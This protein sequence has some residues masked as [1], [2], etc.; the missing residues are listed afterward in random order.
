MLNQEKCPNCGANLSGFNCPYCRSVFQEPPHPQPQI[1]RIETR[2]EYV[3]QYVY[4]PQPVAYM[5][6]I[7]IPEPKEDNENTPTIYLHDTKP[8]KKSDWTSKVFILLM[9]GFLLMLAGITEV[10]V[11]ALGVA[12]IGLIIGKVRLI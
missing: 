5:P 10:F 3:P 2:T 7:T 1:E 9:V 11:L 8:Q 4:V 6:S 12:F